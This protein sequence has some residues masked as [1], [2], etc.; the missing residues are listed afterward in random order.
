MYVSDNIGNIP[1]SSGA[2]YRN[3]RVDELFAQAGATADT[4]Q[5]AAAYKEAQQ[6]LAQDLPYWW[7]VETDFTTA[8][9][10][11]LSGF[12][13]WIGQFAERAWLAQ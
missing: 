6:I 5:R 8:Y 2:T 11:T 4:N 1:F 9:R 3:D 13:P 12:A 10:N 7:L